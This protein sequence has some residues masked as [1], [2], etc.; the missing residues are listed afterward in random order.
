M[1]IYK[2]AAQ[3]GLRFTTPKGALSTEQLFHLSETDLSISIKVEKKNITKDED[4][5][6]DFLVSTTKK[7]DIAQLRF[8]ILKDVY[9][10]KRDER[11]AEKERKDK[12]Q[13]REKILA[14]IEEKKDDSLKSMSVEELEKLL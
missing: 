9:L 6:L 2:K 1:D 3:S 8:D 5:D 10:T 4:N 11:L 7:D 12:K 13:H 14:L